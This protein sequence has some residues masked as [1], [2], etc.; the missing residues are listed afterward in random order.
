MQLLVTLNNYH[1][2]NFWLVLNIFCRFIKKKKLYLPPYDF[3][4]AIILHEKNKMNF[5]LLYP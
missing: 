5:F 1:N 2:W 4:L 3:F